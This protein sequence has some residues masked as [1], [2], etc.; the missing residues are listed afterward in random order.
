MGLSSLFLL[1]AHYSVT[2]VVGASM[3]PTLHSGESLVVKKAKVPLP[4]QIVVFQPPA[5]WEK[6]PSGEELYIKRVAAL[7]GTP[8]IF[9]GTHLTVA[10]HTYTF[11]VPCATKPRRGVVPPGTFLALGDNTQNSRDSRYILCTQPEEDPFVPLDRILFSGTVVFS[12]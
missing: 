3:E 6:E 2:T 1:R 11:P 10:G 4:G 5:A 9:D 7:A 12:L 8:Y